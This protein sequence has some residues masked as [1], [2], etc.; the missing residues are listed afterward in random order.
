MLSY[1]SV[2]ILASEVFPCFQRFPSNPKI[3]NRN[4]RVK[5]E[6]VFTFVNLVAAL[7]TGVATTNTVETG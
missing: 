5:I 4:S 7:S 2:T 6:H 3:E 1:L